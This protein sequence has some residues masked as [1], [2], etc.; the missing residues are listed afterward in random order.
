MTNNIY[1]NKNYN[2]HTIYTDAFKKYH[3]NLVFSEKLDYK[4]A[5]AFCLLIDILTD[6][7]KNYP[8]SK[9]VARSLD[10]NYIIDFYGSFSKSGSIINCQINC[11]FID[12]EYIKDKNYL[13]NI[14]K[15]VFEMIGNPNIV[16]NGFEET[17][18]NIIKSRFILECKKKEEDPNFLAFKDAFRLFDEDNIACFSVYS[19][20][21][22]AKKITR[23][24]L[25]EYYKEFISCK[26]V[27]IFVT[28]NIK[29]DEI[30][31]IIKKYSPFKANKYQ[32]IN[33]EVYVKNRI[34]PKS[35]TI[36]S[37]LNQSTIITIFN[38]NN[39]NK[40]ERE[41]VMPF[42]LNILNNSGLTSKLYENLRNKNSL[43]YSVSTSYVERCNFLNT[44][45]NVR[46][47]TEKKALTLIKKSYNEMKKNITKEE[48]IGAY[49]AYES[50][51]KSIPD[52]ISSIN[53]IYANKY[54][55]GFSTYEEKMKKFKTVTVEDIYKVANKI[56]LNTVYI[57]KGDIKCK[58]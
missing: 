55:I 19:M 12:P 58:K 54:Y 22:Y 40:F 32:M 38:V 1:K 30:N 52:S 51:L 44:K 14:I 31:E 46:I 47:G 21:D 11:D 9:L 3:M 35:K 26:S 39:L 20:V 36:K 13:E 48:F 34:I 37:S 5:V 23:E 53:R 28:G 45:C 8:S 6:A 10:Q 7:S 18:F 27:D 33:D 2:L 50:S 17:T 25:Y 41:F 57:R 49:Y 43:C 15:F 29:S 4:K 16:E 42:Y 56:K 24:E